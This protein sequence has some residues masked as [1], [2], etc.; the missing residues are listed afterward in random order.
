MSVKNLNA[1]IASLDEKFNLNVT[2][3]SADDSFSLSFTLGDR[4]YSI[5]YDSAFNDYILTDLT[6]LTRSIHSSVDHLVESLIESH[7]ALLEALKVT[8]SMRQDEVT[9]IKRNIDG[10]GIGNPRLGILCDQLFKKEQE[11]KSLGE[12]YDLNQSILK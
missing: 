12:S 4:D 10:V 1:C 3:M 5:N 2:S 11:V 9:R 8:K 6:C 7:H